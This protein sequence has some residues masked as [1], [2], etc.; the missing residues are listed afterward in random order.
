MKVEALLEETL[1]CRGPLEERLARCTDPD[2]LIA[3]H[4]NLK[5]ARPLDDG[6]IEFTLAPLDTGIVGFEGYYRCRFEATGDTLR[7]RT[8]GGRNASADGEARFVSRGAQL[9]VHWRGTWA[10]EVDAP[11][12][13]GWLA[14]SALERLIRQEQQAFARRLLEIRT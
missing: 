3:C 6:A 8:T 12:V 11:R 5:W 9:D 2:W 10:W 13:V 7:W 14:K 4:G 1:C